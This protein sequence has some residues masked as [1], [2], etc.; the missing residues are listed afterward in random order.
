MLTAVEVKNA[1]PKDKPYRLADAG[2]LG[3]LVSTAGGKSWQWRH[4]VGGRE[5]ILTLG[6]YPTMTL[7]QARTARDAARHAKSNPT[8]APAT[9]HTFEEVARD[10]HRVNLSRWDPDHAKRIIDSLEA[11][12]FPAFGAE[13]VDSITPPMVLEMLRRL[14]VRGAHEYVRKLRQRCS[15]VFVFGIAS[16]VAANDPAAIVKKALAPKAKVVHQ[17][18]ALDLAEAQATLRVVDETPAR[19]VSRLAMRLLAITAVRQV[20]LRMATWDEFEGL[21]G[22]EPL[23]R[24]PAA[25]AKMRREHLVPLSR[26]AVETIGVLRHVTGTGP[27]PFPSAHN[28]HRPIRKRSVLHAQPRWV[29]RQA[30][31]PRLARVLQYHH[32]RAFPG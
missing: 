29:Q 19:P 18:A 2:G 21:D 30:C 25:H 6:R 22:P 32:E 12:A 7:A 10:W 20:E 24:I 4:R 31:P 16:G 14:E 26:Q 8:A 13:P 9:V 11:N 3:L 1:G 5:Q 17:P 28:A 27:L 23:W 15:A